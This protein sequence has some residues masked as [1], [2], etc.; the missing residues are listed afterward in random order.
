MD[1]F[2][3]SSSKIKNVPKL[4]NLIHIPLR[5]V[6]KFRTILSITTHRSRKLSQVRDTLCRPNLY[7]MVESAM[8]KDRV[9][10]QFPQMRSQNF[11]FTNIIFT[12]VFEWLI[13]HLSRLFSSLTTSN[14][15]EGGKY[16]ILYRPIHKVY[17]KKNFHFSELSYLRDK[18]S[19]WP[20]LRQ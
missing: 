14:G 4:N 3:I 17:F 18:M 11:Y 12:S 13:M 1:I 15:G 10:P 9:I 8:N 16:G 6:P 19:L 7:K 20:Q 5:T 2:W